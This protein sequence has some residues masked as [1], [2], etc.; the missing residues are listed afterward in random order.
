MPTCPGSPALSQLPGGLSAGT[1]L[2]W[3]PEPLCSHWGSRGLCG[4]VS[5]AGQG[6]TAPQLPSLH[7]RCLGL[8]FKGSR[9]RNQA[10]PPGSQWGSRRASPD[11]G[12]GGEAGPSGMQPFCAA[13]ETTA[14]S[15]QRQRESAFTPS[16]PTKTALLHLNAIL[17]HLFLSQQE[18]KSEVLLLW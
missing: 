18:T 6:A 3:G 16:G 17:L 5:Q 2:A 15:D 12:P 13:P 7:R 4:D 1:G 14:F 10:T 11:S 8:A 9:E